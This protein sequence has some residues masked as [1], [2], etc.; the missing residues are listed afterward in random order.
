[1]F[2]VIDWFLQFLVLTRKNILI[3]VRNWKTTLFV[4]LSPVLIVVGLNLMSTVLTNNIEAMLGGKRQDVLHPKPAMIPLLPPC[5]GF[6]ARK[7]VTLRFSPPDALPIIQTILTDN[8]LS[9]TDYVAYDNDTVLSDFILMNPNTTM[10]GLNFFGGVSQHGDISYVILYNDTET[11]SDPLSVEKPVNLIPRVQLTVD[12]AIVKH[13]LSKLWGQ[14]FNQFP[15]AK[16]Y[17]YNK[18]QDVLNDNVETNIVSRIIDISLRSV[19]TPKVINSTNTPIFEKA[20]FEGFLQYILAGFFLQFSIVMFWIAL[21]YYIVWEKSLNLRFAMTIMG[22]RNNSW[23]H[24]WFVAGFVQ[25]LCAVLAVYVTG[26]A[27][28]MKIFLNTNPLIILII[29]CSFGVSLISVAMLLSVI[30]TSNRAAS[31]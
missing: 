20:T 31:M 3:N 24:S 13:K 17:V 2:F 30:T 5:T 6:G 25:M 21:L 4:L 23:W 11:R 12:N 15:K 27:F 26:L 28:K 18:F 7:C 14:S 1:M 29:F 16:N 10:I 22:M 8:Q 19:A 9:A